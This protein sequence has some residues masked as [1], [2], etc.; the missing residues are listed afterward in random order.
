MAEA[1]SLCLGLL[2]PIEMW[3][4]SVQKGCGD[5][6]EEKEV[7]SGLHCMSEFCQSSLF[8]SLP[9]LNHFSLEV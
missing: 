9:F 8:Y 3:L 5:G 6:C 7:G 2:R 1:S 4:L